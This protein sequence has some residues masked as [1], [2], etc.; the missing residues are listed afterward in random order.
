MLQSTE[1]DT[2][3]SVPKYAETNLTQEQ[4]IQ[5]LDSLTAIMER[6]KCFLDERL[7][8]NDLA[9]KINSNRNYLSQIIN[10]HYQTNFN[11][12]INEFRV[13]EARKLLINTDYQNYTIEGIAQTVGFN[14]K[15]TF[16]AAFK[17]FTG[18]TPSFFRENSKIQ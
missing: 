13:K 1:V 16:N 4:K 9:K 17:K 15:A 2:S 12:F 5:L 18:V 7:T 14:S 3:Y 8:I 10:E 11:N 6:E